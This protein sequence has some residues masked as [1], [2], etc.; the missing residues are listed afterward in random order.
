MQE[1]FGQRAIHFK[2]W[3]WNDCP[4]NI[5]FFGFQEWILDEFPKNVG[6]WVNFPIML[7]L[8]WISQYCWFYGEFTNK[9]A[10]RNCFGAGLLH[11]WIWC[12]S[13]LGNMRSIS[14]L[15]FGMIVPIM[16]DFGWITQQCCVLEQFSKNCLVHAWIW[17]SSTLGNVPSVSIGSHLPKQDT[18]ASNKLSLLQMKNRQPCFAANAAQLS[19][20]N[21]CTTYFVE[22]SLCNDRLI[23]LFVC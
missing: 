23:S 14:S 2:S 19:S 16:L 4:N 12:R 1:H 17:C 18:F 20:R 8:W 13:I 6:F 10:F 3:I 7:V 5:L 15:G 11:A 22:I 21:V 9:V